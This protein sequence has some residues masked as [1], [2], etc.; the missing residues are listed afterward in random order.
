MAETPTDVLVAGYP[1]IDGATKDFESLGALVRDTQVSIDGVI[2][3]THAPDGSVAVRQTGGNLG[4]EG[5]GG[6]GVGL[7]V[8]PSRRRCWRRS[9]SGLSRAGSSASSSTTASS[10]TSTTILTAKEN[11]MSQSHLVID[12]PIKGPANAK[13]LPEE[14]PPLMPDLAAAQDDLGTV[15]FSRFMVEGD[16]KLLFLSDIDGETDQHIERLVESAGP[17]FDAILTHVDNPPATPVADNP[18]RATKWLKRHVREPLDTYFAYGDASVQ[19]IK[20]CARAAGFTGNTS[21]GT[22]LTYI[23]F[24]SRVQAFAVKQVAGALMRR[25]GTQSVGFHRDAAC[26][27]LGAL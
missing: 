8:G 19:D 15:H 9:P 6:G 11:A 25:Q 7:A 22:L 14:L 17:V 3:V 24:K 4:R 2:L 16:E 23:S 20:A 5:L 27:P 26:R 13:A 21:Q 10:R 12:F 18:E 1:D